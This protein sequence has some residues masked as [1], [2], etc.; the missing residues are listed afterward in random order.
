MM[1]LASVQYSQTFMSGKYLIATYKQLPVPT[2]INKP[3]STINA[4]AQL[5]SHTQNAEE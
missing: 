2:T 3:N 4:I 5:W 1:I